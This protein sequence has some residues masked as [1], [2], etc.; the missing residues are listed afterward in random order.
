MSL[1]RPLLT[2]A[3]LALSACASTP[4]APA[5]R[6]ALSEVHAWMQ[7]HYESTAQAARDK[8]Y[9]AISLVMAPVF[10]EQSSARWLYVEQALAAT[11]ERPYRQR[12][13]RLRE[14]A[15]G[16]VV[17]EVFLLREPERFVR[18]FERGSLAELTPDML[19]PRRGCEVYLRKQGDAY[20]G[21]TRGTGCSS[22]LRGARYATAEVQLRDGELRSWDRGFDAAGNQ[23]WG[24]G[25]GPYIFLRAAAAD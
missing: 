1:A 17:S 14:N 22:D 10:P 3:L 20:L 6:D 21:G 9:F 2:V 7:G 19:E 5:P 16:E 23:V 4:P 11:P 15:Q 25:N 24:A 18:G 12:V 8:D 13:Y